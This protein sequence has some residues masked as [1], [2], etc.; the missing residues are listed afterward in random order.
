MWPF[1]RY[2]LLKSGV[3]NGAPDCHCHLLPGVDDGMQTMDET[4]AALRKY[5]EWGVRE[6]WLTPHIME[7]IPNHVAKLKHRFESLCETI[8][9]EV[10][11]S[12]GVVLG[13]ERPYAVT[14]CMTVRLMAENMM[15]GLLAERL[16]AGELLT[17]GIDGSELLVETSYMQPPMGM[18]DMLGAIRDKGLTPVIAHPERYVYM[19]TEDYVRL[20]K[21][22]VK[23]QLNLTSLVGAYGSDAQRKAELLL[24]M[25]A[26]DYRGTDC[27][28]LESLAHALK[29]SVSKD[30]PL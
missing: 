7:D 27:H 3:L 10:N 18:M 17:Y 11:A 21:W 5:E 29:K 22:G 26:Y 23:M 4:V 30:L 16:E 12:R 1:N 9:A 20:R 2:T 25:G 13:D 8:G 15:D 6:V 14:E 28:R 19:T 24:G